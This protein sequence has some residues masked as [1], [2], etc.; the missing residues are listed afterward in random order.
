MTVYESLELDEHSTERCW[1]SRKDSKGGANNG[2]LRTMEN[3]IY[4]LSFVSSSFVRT[5]LQYTI[6]CFYTIR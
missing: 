2:T 6:Q 4:D 3:L 1:L 5:E